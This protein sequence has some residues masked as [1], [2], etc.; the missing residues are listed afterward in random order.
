MS[1][2]AS[3][4]VRLLV[5]FGLMVAWLAVL[6][7]YQRHSRPSPEIVRK[8]FHLGGGLLGL[9][10]PWLFDDVRP[11]LVLALAFAALFAALRL[12]PT[13]ARGPGQVLSR[14]KRNTIGEFWFLASLCLL[15]WLAHGD[16]LLYGVPVLVLAVADTFA[17]LVGAE[18]GKRHFA[19]LR[20]RKSVEGSVA[21]FL[22]AFLCVHVPVLLWSGAGRKES[23]LIAFSLGLLVTMAEAAAW[24]GLDNF[25]VP[26]FTYG[27][28]RVFLRL[29]IAELITHL[30]FL[31]ALGLFVRGWRHRTT[32]ADDA[33]FGG[34]AW[35][36]VVWAVSDWRWIVPPLALFVSYLALSNRT[37]LDHERVFNFPVLLATAAAGQLWLLLYWLSGRPELFLAFAA[38][39]GSNLAI[40]ALV[41]DAHAHPSASWAAVAVEDAGKGI[42]LVVLPASI[43]VAQLGGGAMLLGLGALAVLSST[44]AFALI[45]PDL[46]RYPIDSRRWVRQA[47]A[48]TAGS[49]LC[50]IPYAGELRSWL[51]GVW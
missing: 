26:L 30:T 39:F 38:A 8:V 11:V 29:S 48:T 1:L 50:L 28:L 40:V 23:L 41:R 5:A 46:S 21:F 12:V 13:L 2:S 47:I 51:S 32:L 14:V 45:Q 16:R 4:W 42:L 49:A 17:A 20:G 22:A 35:G 44:L 7:L 27:L 24:W 31:L 37:V 6:R 36:Y 15:F 25:I 9:M 3:P 34:V 33:L 19:T 43:A 18:Y 10:L